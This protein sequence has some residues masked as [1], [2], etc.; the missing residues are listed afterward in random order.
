MENAK[1]NPTRVKRV[2][3]LRAIRLK[4]LDCCCQQIAEVRTCTITSC[5]LWPFRMGH[6]PNR[7]GLGGKIGAV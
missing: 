1:P 6:N 2:T 4:C 7:K 5:E 3:P